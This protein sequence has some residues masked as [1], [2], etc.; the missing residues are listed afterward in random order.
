M[1]EKGNK[2]MW[3]YLQEKIRKRIIFH[4]TNWEN[5]TKNFIDKKALLKRHGGELEM[6]DGP[7]GTQL[8]ESLIFCEPFF[9]SN[10]FT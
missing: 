8:W 4:G 10:Y 1:W 2:N 3:Y 6:P 5:L 7:F 9:E